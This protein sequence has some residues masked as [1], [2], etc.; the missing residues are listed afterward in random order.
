MVKISVSWSKVNV[1]ENIRHVTLRSDEVYL[2]L[3]SF[4]IVLVLRR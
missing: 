2:H 3:G 1:M 4:Q